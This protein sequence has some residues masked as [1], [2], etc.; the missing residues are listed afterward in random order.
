MVIF[1]KIWFCGSSLTSSEKTG[2]TI[3]TKFIYGR[4]LKK[5]FS[6]NDIK[7]EINRWAF[8]NCPKTFQLS[9][10]DLKRLIYSGQI[11]TSLRTS[12]SSSYW[13]HR[14]ELLSINNRNNNRKHRNVGYKF[15]TVERSWIELKSLHLGDFEMLCFWLFLLK[16]F[17]T[18]F[19]KNDRLCQG[20]NFTEG[21]IT[22]EGNKI[23]KSYILLSSNYIRRK[24]K[25][26]KK[27]KSGKQ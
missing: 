20:C 7:N 14:V 5:W 8:K 26:P 10:G 11:S 2:Q 23:C 6:W 19:S 12:Y 22:L 21:S 15:S 16:L 3:A 25:T 17:P 24:A 9:I 27:D 1:N 4:T 13:F 18:F